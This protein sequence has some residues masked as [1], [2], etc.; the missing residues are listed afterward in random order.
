MLAGLPITTAVVLNT[1]GK[2]PLYANTLAIFLFPCLGVLVVHGAEFIY[3][4]AIEPTFV[5]KR[6]AHSVPIAVGVTLVVVAAILQ[7]TRPPALDGPTGDPAAAVRFL[8]DTAK[9]GDLVYVHASA[10][11][12]IKLYLQLLHSQA[13]TAV[14]GNTGW[15]CCTRHHQFETGPVDDSY[16]MTDFENTVRARHGRVLLVFADRQ[17]HWHWLGR[18]ERQII[19]R[20]LGDL[21]CHDSGTFHA[22]SIVI[23]DVQCSGS[24]YS[25]SFSSSQASS[26]SYDSAPQS[27]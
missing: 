5:S 15:P 1:L 10:E 12:Q 17:D 4:I 6:W 20:H 2:Y 23:D 26:R 19:L 27:Q 24:I 8:D 11:E 13:L 21:A 25:A 18:N 7:Y 22:G 14:F 3:E 16:V 9:P